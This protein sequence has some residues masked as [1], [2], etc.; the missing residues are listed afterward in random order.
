MASRLVVADPDP[1]CAVD[2]RLLDPQPSFSYADTPSLTCFLPSI[3]AEQQST[4]QGVKRRATFNEGSTLRI[5]LSRL[6]FPQERT[7]Y[8]DGRV[9]D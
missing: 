5:V 3:A 2:G 6:H 4:H 1:A 9:V 7:P 8:P